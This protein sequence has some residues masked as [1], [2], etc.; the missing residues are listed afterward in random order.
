MVFTPSQ[1]KLPCTRVLLNVLGSKVTCSVPSSCHLQV[2]LLLHGA[3]PR[4]CRPLQPGAHH[5]PA[6]TGRTLLPGLLQHDAPE[7]LS[8]PV[9][10]SRTSLLTRTIQG[11]RRWSAAGTSW[12]SSNEE[13]WRENWQVLPTV[14]E[15]S[16][17]LQLP[18]TKTSQRF[19]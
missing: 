11:A 13:R 7:G 2:R 10:T 8:T 5:L 12:S 15:P 1:K 17:I 3:G 16:I 14:D 9:R 18:K 6:Q 4:A 19:K